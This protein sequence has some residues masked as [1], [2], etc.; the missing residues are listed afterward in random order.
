MNRS[1][2]P[3]DSEPVFLKCDPQTSSGAPN[4]TATLPGAAEQQLESIWQLGLPRYLE[5]RS[6][7]RIVY[8]PAI[9]D[10]SLRVNDQFGHVGISALGADAC[11]PSRIHRLSSKPEGQRIISQN[12]EGFV[13]PYS[14]R[15]VHYGC[16]ADRVRESRQHSKF[17]AAAARQARTDGDKPSRLGSR[18]PG[19]SPL[20]GEKRC[21]GSQDCL[22]SLSQ[23]CEKPQEKQQVPCIGS[24]LSDIRHKA[25]YE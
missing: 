8:N 16:R 21:D 20:L 13:E 18:P 7:G 15:N 10:G 4:N 24:Y 22:A 12:I 25:I 6:A 3:L 17:T 23:L 14:Y 9:N 11:E 1:I 5:A 2:Q 19:V